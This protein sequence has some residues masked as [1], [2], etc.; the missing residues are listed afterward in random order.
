MAGRRFSVPDEMNLGQYLKY[1]RFP[2]DRDQ[3]VRHA[4]QHAAPQVVIGVLQAMPERLYRNRTDVIRESDRARGLAPTIPALI[5]VETE[6]ALELL[7]LSNLVPPPDFTEY[8]Q[9]SKYPREKSGLIRH[10]QERGASFENIA[11]LGKLPDRIYQDAKDVMRSARRVRAGNL[12]GGDWKVQCEAV[13]VQAQ[14]V[15]DRTARRHR[16]NIP[17]R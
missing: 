3:L 14:S 5:A 15:G 6:S 10:F 4:R 9:T 2:S 17:P 13:A 8:L 1:H 7:A 11:L 12:Y 16:P